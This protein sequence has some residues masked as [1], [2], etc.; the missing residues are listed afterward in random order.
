M[1]I[2]DDG[3]TDDTYSIATSIAKNDPRIKVFT[4]ENIGV[5]RLGETYNKGLDHSTGKYIAILECDDL[6]EPQ[7]L[8]KQVGIMEKNPAVVMA[9][10]KTMV[11]SDDLSK[12]FDIRPVYHYDY[13]NLYNNHPAGAIIK[14]LATGSFIPA[15]TLLI[16]KTALEEIGGF[17]QS[18]GLP[19]VDFTTEL[20]LSLK[21]P[22][23]FDNEVYG[24]WRIYPTQTTKKHAVEMYK[25][26]TGFVKEHLPKV[27]SLS[28]K[29]K[30]KVMHYYESMGLVA[31]SRSGRFKLVRKEYR[32]A[33]H[34]YLKAI[35]FKTRGKWMW[36]LRSMIGFMMSIFHL[37]V[38]WIAKLLGKKT[39]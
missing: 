11:V 25:G 33:R 13:S 29:E 2:L 26:F 22:F 36:R 7:K 21:G 5:F 17:I 27:N 3:S 30:R 31:Y 18:H 24:K 12:T 34:D 32:S 37:D 8:E 1:L 39:F 16:R 35:T 6:W 4:Q 9:W 38:E 23:H 28:E 19:L 14:L 20:C 10:A 15:L